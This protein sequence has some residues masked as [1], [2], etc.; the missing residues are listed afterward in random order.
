[1]EHEGVGVDVAIIAKL[2]NGPMIRYRNTGG[3]AQGEAARRAGIATLTWVLLEQ[4]RL[5]L[6]YD[7][8]GSAARKVAQLLSM[9]LYDVFPPEL[10]GRMSGCT[11][12]A[13]GRLAAHCLTDAVERHTERMTLPSPADLIEQQD[14]VDRLKPLLMALSYR[15]REIIKLRNGIGDGHA[16][17]LEEVGKIFKVTRERIRAVEARAMRKLKALRGRDEE[18]DEQQG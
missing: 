7:A 2:R 1:M 15:E 3:I 12:T 6:R 16:H 9:S 10:R 14:D 8:E 13:Y 11:R 18:L 4:M 17:T 5:G